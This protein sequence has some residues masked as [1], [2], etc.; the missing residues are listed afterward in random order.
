M[1]DDDDEYDDEVGAGCYRDLLDRRGDRHRDE[2]DRH[3]QERRHHHRAAVRQHPQQGGRSQDGCHQGGQREL[4][5]DHRGQ[6]AAGSACQMNSL[7]DLAE[8]GLA[9]PRLSAARS[10]DRDDVVRRRYPWPLGPYRQASH[11][12]QA[13]LRQQVPAQQEQEVQE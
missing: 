5:H 6:V 4:V 9:C 7:A 10:T 1:N 12:H 8:V 13:W 2:V 3:Q 11:H